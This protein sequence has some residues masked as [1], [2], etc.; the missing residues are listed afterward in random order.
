MSAPELSAWVVDWFLLGSMATRR[1]KG[2]PEGG[3][4]V[5][6][7]GMVWQGLP[8]VQDKLLAR[9]EVSFRQSA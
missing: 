5:W 2:R 8:Q 3:D 6:R 7:A 9:F 1:I 4:G